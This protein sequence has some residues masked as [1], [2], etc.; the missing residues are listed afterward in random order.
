MERTTDRG[1]L[2]MRAMD[3]SEADWAG[4]VPRH[5]PREF[6][7]FDGSDLMLIVGLVLLSIEVVQINGAQLNQVW[8]AACLIVLLAQ[9]KI[10]VTGREVFVYGL[11][12][13]TALWLTFVGDFPRMKEGQQIIK[14]AIVYPAFFLLGRYYGWR[15]A[16]GKRLPFGYLAIAAFLLVQIGLQ[17]YKVPVLYRPVEHTP[18]AIN[19]S[20][21]ERNW[22]SFYFF[23]ASYVVFLQSRRR[24]VDAMMFLAFGVANALASGSKSVLVAYGI[25]IITQLKG[26]RVM[27][28]L[29]LAMGAATFAYLFA[30]E[31]SGQ[32]L[33]TRLQEER[34]FALV[35]SIGLLD[36]NWLGYGFGF[37]EGYFAQAAFFIRGLGV[38][39]NSIFCAPLDFMLIAG[40]PGLLAWLMYFC[41][42]GLGWS[43]I[44]CVAPIAAWSLTNP[45]H[46][47]ETVWFYLGYLVSYGRYMQRWGT[48]DLRAMRFAAIA[49]LSGSRQRSVT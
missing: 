21:I 31:L 14:F 44:G 5:Q 8:A 16:S 26:H 9:R 48:H 40:I 25:A 33:S 20:F 38:G 28:G 36:R 35:T 4:L 10:A 13:S 29:L 12:L 24:P 23:A 19:G 45:M 18:G 3:D 27:K 2:A 32:V 43:V 6:A 47:N 17:I 1:E 41:G 11:F 49:P 7:T 39:A 22:L 30:P 34:G 37:V 15:Y 42:F 46:Q